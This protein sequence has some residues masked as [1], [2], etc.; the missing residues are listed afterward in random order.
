MQRYKTKYDAPNPIKD[1]GNKKNGLYRY[2]LYVAMEKLPC[3]IRYIIKIMPIMV[4]K[5]ICIPHVAP[6]VSRYL[7]QLFLP[8][9]A[10]FKNSIL[11]MIIPPSST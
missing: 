10:L 7:H 9:Y 2:S 11:D 1:N 4:P 6:I 8:S 5:A 3:M